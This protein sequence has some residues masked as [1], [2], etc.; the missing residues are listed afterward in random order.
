MDILL[1]QNIYWQ[2]RFLLTVLQCPLCHKWGDCTSAG[3][4]LD[5]LFYTTG[6]LSASHQFYTL[7][8]TVALSGSV[9]VPILFFKFAF[10]ILGPLCL[11]IN[12]GSNLLIFIQTHTRILIRLIIIY[13][14]IWGEVIILSL[15]IQKCRIGFHLLSSS[16]EEANVLREKA[17]QNGGLIS[18]RF[19]LSRILT[20]HV[21][22]S[23]QHFDTFN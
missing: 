12:F 23:W 2:D 18:M 17:L 6:F 14:L 9:S 15:L 11:H 4:Q 20:L 16:Y 5:F 8:I 7:V 19:L 13:K 22:A 10:G 1:T 21:L 3:L